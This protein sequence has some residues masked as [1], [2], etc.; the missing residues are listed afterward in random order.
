M[1][2]WYNKGGGLDKETT[3]MK[4]LR[5]STT[6]VFW[7]LIGVFLIIL[8]QF[9]IPALNNFFSGSKLFLIPMAVFCL[10]GL[11]LLILSLRE[12]IESKL[13]RFL[14]LTGASAVGFFIFVILH[15]AFYA[16]GTISRQIFFLNYLIESLQ[17][18]FFLVAIFICPIAF[19]VGLISSV[20]LLIKNH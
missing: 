8:C 17:I 15:N 7:G 4:G 16:L 19:L 13:K 12:K 9:F 10:L 18:A 1:G 20:L 11:V 3:T 5:K 6:A 2:F 14:I